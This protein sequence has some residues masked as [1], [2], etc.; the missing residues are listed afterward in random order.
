MLVNSHS[1]A[2]SLYTNVATIAD[3]YMLLFNSPADY[4]HLQSVLRNRMQTHKNTLSGKSAFLISGSGTSY[5]VRQIT[6]GTW[7]F[8][9]YANSTLAYGDPDYFWKRAFEVTLNP[10]VTLQ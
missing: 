3:Q 9:G 6:G 7:S 4:S 2:N 5:D 8:A 10:V 1:R